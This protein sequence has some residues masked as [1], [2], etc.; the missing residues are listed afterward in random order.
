MH[1]CKLYSSLLIALFLQGTHY[2]DLPFFKLLHKLTYIPTNLLHLASYPAKD[3]H[4]H[5]PLNLITDFCH[6]NSGYI[7]MHNAILTI[8]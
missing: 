5:H 8:S 3:L 2:P 7:A 1:A 6:T 4:T